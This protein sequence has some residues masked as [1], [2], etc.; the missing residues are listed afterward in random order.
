MWKFG[1]RKGVLKRRC[2]GVRY[3]RKGGKKEM[4]RERERERERRNESEENSVLNGG[5]FF[6]VV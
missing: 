2:F 3:D 1:V 6:E 4:K 5:F